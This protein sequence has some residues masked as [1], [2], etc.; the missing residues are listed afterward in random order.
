[1][2]GKVGTDIQD[3]KCS[4]LVCTALQEA[5]PAQR[6]TIAE[7]YGKDDGESIGRVKA[8]YQCAFS[9]AAPVITECG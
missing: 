5:T 6:A 7:N 1:V 9:C 2:L 4:W 3:N 8:V